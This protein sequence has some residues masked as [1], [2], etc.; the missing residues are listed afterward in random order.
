[1][2]ILLSLLI[3]CQVQAGNV[4]GFEREVTSFKKAA[5]RQHVDIALDNLTITL[6][7]QLPKD[8]VAFCDSI[9]QDKLIIVNKVIWD[10]ADNMK[11]QFILW[12][13]MGHCILHRD[14][15]NKM[16][17]MNIPMSYMYPSDNLYL[18][19]REYFLNHL[20][21]YESE[22]FHPGY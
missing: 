14:H 19:H 20:P 21:E 13:E 22:L 10:S 11:R 16:N 5:K 18:L 6:A 3:C 8:L 9:G 4:K 17:Y 1:M 7:D 2:K 12:H 15:L